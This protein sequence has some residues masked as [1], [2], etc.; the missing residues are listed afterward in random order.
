MVTK[1]G[2]HQ[3][4]ECGLCVAVTE[5]HQVVLPKSIT[6]CEGCLPM[7]HFSHFRLPIAAFSI[8]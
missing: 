4:L 6:C 2:I 5:S 3:V 7:V 1:D 8:Y